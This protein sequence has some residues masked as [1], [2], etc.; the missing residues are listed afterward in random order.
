MCFSQQLHHSELLLF[1][2]FVPTDLLR[3]PGKTNL[4]MRIIIGGGSS[5]LR[6]RSYFVV[7][8]C[9]H[10]P[11]HQIYFPLDLHQPTRQ[12]HTKEGAQMQPQYLSVPL[13]GAEEDTGHLKTPRSPHKRQ[14]WSPSPQ[15]HHHEIEIHDYDGHDDM[16]TSDQTLRRTSSAPEQQRKRDLETLMSD[17][18]LKK[19][20]GPRGSFD[21]LGRWKKLVI[22]LALLGVVLVLV[23]HGV[24]LEG[25]KGGLREQLFEGVF[26]NV[27]GTL[28]SGVMDEDK[29]PEAITPAEGKVEVE[30]EEDDIGAE[31]DSE[32]LEEDGGKAL[33][34]FDPS[35]AKPKGG[36]QDE[37][38]EAVEAEGVAEQPQTPPTPTK[39]ITKDPP[40]PLGQGSEFILF[41]TI[42]ND[43]PPRHALG[44]TLNNVKFIL[45]NEPE[46]PGLDRR[47]VVNRIVDGDQE[48]AVIR[49]LEERKQRYVHVPVVLEEYANR[50]M[51]YE[52]YGRNDMI[53]TPT[54]QNLEHKMQLAIIDN[55]YHNKNLYIM[56]NNGARNL[57]I[58]EGIKA[59]ARWI[60]PWDGNC[61]LT[62]QAWEAV[63]S[64]VR[65]KGEEAKYFQVPMV[66]MQSNDDLFNPE[67]KP[68]ANEEPQLI[69]RYDAQERFD[70]T[71][72]YGRRPKVE[73][74]WRLR[75]PGP[76]DKWPQ[77]I[78]PWEKH[79]WTPSM[80]V[81]GPDSVPKAGWVARLYSGQGALENH[82]AIV[83]RG[84]S[85]V[86]GIENILTRM[87]LRVLSELNGFTSDVLLAYNETVLA[88]EKRLYESGKDPHIN[89][90]IAKL[91]SC[92]DQALTHGPFSVVNKTEF[93]PSHDKHDYYTPSPYFWPNPDTP[94]GLPYIRKDGHRVPGTEL[95]DS[96]SNR[97]DRSRLASL[98][99]N[100]TCLA[101]GW[102]FTG[103][104]E[105]AD[106]ATLNIR[107]WFL[108]PETKM[109]PH[110]RFA[111]IRWGYNNN[112][113][114]NFG[115]I[116][117]KDLYYLLDA[118]RLIERSGAMTDAEK[119]DLRQWL[120]DFSDY[121]LI[122]KQG[123]SE[124]SQLNNHGTYYDVQLASIAA[125]VGNM[126]RYLNHTERA[127]SRITTQF[128]K[129]GTLPREMVRPTA[130]HYMMF[131]LQ[132]WMVL[133]RL[134]AAGGVDLFDFRPI[135]E[136]MDDGSP[137]IE[138]GLKFAVP[139]FN[140]T[141]THS[142]NATEDMGRMLPLY[143]AGITYF[144]EMR[145]LTPQIEYSNI[146]DI[147]DIE[148]LF[149]T[150]D[151]IQPFWNL[152]LI[153]PTLLGKKI[154]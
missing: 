10:F 80:D 91:V 45:D 117:T 70:E 24:S 36:T 115:V 5:Q 114:A 152:G 93:P 69:F 95:Y 44:Q 73:L 53:H 22:A 85:R 2:A 20:D 90:L 96:Q 145:S 49:L 58:E 23:L 18:S 4:H 52:G 142:Q 31:T 27:T 130:L 110:M 3:Q 99:G 28:G 48:Q 109:N 41:R 92:A 116:E 134:A 154:E 64:A 84:I 138:R 56:N 60:L 72:R 153:S 82:G 151:G 97:F 140:S 137:A 54:F 120:V 67:F 11:R 55:M 65:E 94:D 123:M 19:K 102:Y 6:I 33:P 59:G 148:P 62:S 35:V 111:Q 61:Y 75:V 112:T 71:M 146:P 122:S 127:K 106:R 103:N 147:Y 101:L 144:P 15:R 13:K 43:L 38:Y 16:N 125:F 100:T 40:V 68:V 104:Q 47:W 113:G 32:V 121:L 119:S 81:N 29:Q 143:Y 14:F 57:M 107:T 133:G 42:G 51:I 1:V 126:G 25:S 17:D 74:L 77:S 9:P 37:Q 108:D 132:G 129:D 63:A 76:W 7:V 21:T 131:T 86:N 118:I 98:F 78:G 135:K 79:K 150:H 39:P 30:E 66:R 87:D 141:W 128:K 12:K 50:T 34:E 139:Q 124:Y 105:Y 89:G 26:K 46:L 136:P 83:D 8:F 88:E 149:F